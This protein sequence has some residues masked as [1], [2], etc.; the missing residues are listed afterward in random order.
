LELLGWAQ[1]G[2]LAARIEIERGATLDVSGLADVRLPMS[3]KL[4]TIPRVGQN[5]LADSP[6]QRN[7]W[8]YRQSVTI[9]GSRSGIR[10][11]GLE[12]FGSPLLNAAGYIENQPRTIDQMLVDGGS[13][14]VVGREL[15]TRSGS[16]LNAD[17]GFIH[18]LGGIVKTTRLLGADGR[19]YDIA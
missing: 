9:D 16:Q 5:E 11:D 2:A 10:D 6:L 18:Y 13:I 19:I 4:I 8:L 15:V 12:W 14:T 3:A 1:S 17:G 7:G